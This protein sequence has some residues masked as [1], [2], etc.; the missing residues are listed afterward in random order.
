MACEPKWR[1]TFE[2][3]AS[4]WFCGSQNATR[5]EG[6]TLNY[7]CPHCGFVFSG[8]IGAVVR[9]RLSSCFARAFR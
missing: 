6:G 7:V 9:S 3:A 4:L 8:S 1:R 2:R 5:P